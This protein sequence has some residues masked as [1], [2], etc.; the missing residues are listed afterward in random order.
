MGKVMLFL[1]SV[2]C[3]STLYAGIS[4]DTI[5]ETPDGP[6]EI[7]LLKVG[8]KIVCFN[9]NFL[10]EEKSVISIEEVETDNIVEITTEDG[11][12]IFVAADQQLFVPNKWLR[13]DQLSLGDFLLKKDRSFLGIT[14]IRHKNESTK[15]RFLV[16]E[17]HHNFLASKNGVLVHNGPICGAIGYWGVKI[18]SYVGICAGTTVAVAAVAGT[19]PVSGPIIGGLGGATTAGLAIAAP[20]GSTAT[21][22]AATAAGTGTATGVAIGAGLQASATIAATAVAVESASTSVG[23]FLLAIP[24]IP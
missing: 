11:E 20:L 18:G 16:V 19:L 10:T 5:V 4:R 21:I 24:F 17:E 8:D 15:L 22:V 3:I 14:C 13:A 2:L 1:Y 9:N 7:G 23:L 6:R 12:T